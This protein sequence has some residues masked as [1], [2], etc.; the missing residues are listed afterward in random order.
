MSVR[1]FTRL[2]NAFSK[3]Y[4]NHCHMVAIYYAYYNFC[5]V[6]QTFASDAR[7]GSWAGRSLGVRVMSA[8]EKERRYLDSHKNELLKE[9]GGKILVI[10][11]EQVTGAFDTIEEALR[12]AVEKHGLDSVLIRR[13]SEA[14]IEFS[15][16]ALTL[17]ILNQ[18][19]TVNSRHKLNPPTVKSST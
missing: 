15:A 6:H 13:P 5:R 11:G 19:C 8:L 10:A 4:E 14:Q 12:G 2:T 17:G 3:R 7:D 1:R 18:S 9:Y 16:P